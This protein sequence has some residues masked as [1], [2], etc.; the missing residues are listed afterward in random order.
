LA[1]SFPLIYSVLPA[2]GDDG[3]YDVACD[4]SGCRC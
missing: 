2:F 1:H 3:G 4:V